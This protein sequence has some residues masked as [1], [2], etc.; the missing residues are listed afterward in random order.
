M[1]LGNT[2]VAGNTATTGW[3]DV[4]RVTGVFVS[5]GNNLIGNTDGS[6]TA[7]TGSD[8]TGTG[9][10]PLLPV[11]AALGNYGGPTQTMPLLP[12]SPAIDA[13]SNALIPGGVTTD[14][15]G[16]SRIV[17]STVDIGAFESSGFTFAVT[18]GSGQST[19]AYTTF[20]APLVAT[21]TA[22]NASEPVAGGLVTFTAPGSG[23]SATLSG[24]LATLSATGT[25]TVTAAANNIAGSY[26]VS[27]TATGITIP[28]SF[29]LTNL[30]ATL[31]VNNPTDTPV[32]GETDLRQAITLANSLTGANTITFDPTVFATPQTITLNGTQLSLTNTT[33]TE[34]ITGPA[35]GVTISGN[36]ASRVFLVNASV[37]ASISGLTISGG[38]VTGVGGG[39]D[40]LGTVTLT[41]VTLSGNTASTIG[42]GLYNKA[43]ATLIGCTVSGNSVGIRGGGLWSSGTITLIND[44]LSGNSASTNTGGGLYNKATATLTGCTVSGNTAA[45]GGG[46]CGYGSGADDDADQRHHQRQ[47]RLQWRRPVR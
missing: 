39:L 30:P 36:H 35:A 45:V 12:G 47:H 19:N 5:S 17:N 34:T 14:Q 22:N 38:T 33:G 40:N 6:N 25:A 3:P 15:R 18:S 11:I 32:A 43:T 20:S 41:N 24:S 27:A 44:I 7:W 46:I 10:A 4:G 23:A 26:S 8:L 9:A 37:T 29:S 2:L 13:G 21:V 31:V 28:A 42:G 1:T 16:D